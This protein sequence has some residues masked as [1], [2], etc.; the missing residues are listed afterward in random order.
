MLAVAPPRARRCTPM[1]TKPKT[2]PEYVIVTEDGDVVTEDGDVVT[3]DDDV[4]TER[5]LRWAFES[6]VSQ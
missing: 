4:V 5:D 2:E 6:S 1:G 3:E